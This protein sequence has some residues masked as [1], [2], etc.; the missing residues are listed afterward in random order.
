MDRHL[1]AD[2]DH[3][4]QHVAEGGVVEQIVVA[5]PRTIPTNRRG[6]DGGAAL[7]GA[8]PVH[9]TCPSN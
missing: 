2:V 4:R 6:D 5:S 7:A 9:A 3:L 1:F 8:C